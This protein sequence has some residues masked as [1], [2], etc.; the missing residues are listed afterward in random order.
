MDQVY[1]TS[2]PV[3]GALWTEFSIPKDLEPTTPAENGQILVPREQKNGVKEVEQSKFQ[4]GVGKLLHM[5]RWSRPELL[6]SICELSRHMKVAAA[7]VH[8][9]V[10]F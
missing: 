6:N 7:P 4:T 8:T 10:M 5:M 3:D 2:A 1:T 9:K